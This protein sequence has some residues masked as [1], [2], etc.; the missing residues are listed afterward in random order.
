MNFYI[1]NIHRELGVYRI[2]DFD[3][4]QFDIA[5]FWQ[6]QARTFPRISKI[7]SWL[8]AIPASSASDDWTFSSAGATLTPRRTN[9]SSGTLAALT[10]IHMNKD[11]LVGI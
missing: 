10:F 6:S 5:K 9:L 11:F 4:Q 8:L 7:A 1:F 2:E 3:V